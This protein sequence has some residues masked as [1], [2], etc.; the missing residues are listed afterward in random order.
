[1]KALILMTLLLMST[2]LLAT[3]FT[4]TSGALV[5]G[6]LKGIES[7]S[8]YIM[9][10]SNKLHIVKM[11]DIKSINDGYGDVAPMWKRKKP[12]MDV[13]ASEHELSDNTVP[14]VR[15]LTQQHKADIDS[16]TDREFQQHLSKAQVV[17]LKRIN[18]T[19]WT[20]FG[21]SIGISV[22]SV[23]YITTK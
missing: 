2:L 1:M 5:V 9:D 12:F 10:Y 3:D 15:V 18:T 14:N 8:M 20:I 21:I 6:E 13:V 7:G 19:L 11:D 23:I 4:L 16:M 17:E 22:A